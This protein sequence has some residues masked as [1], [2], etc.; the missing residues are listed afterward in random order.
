M[1]MIVVGMCFGILIWWMVMKIRWD[2]ACKDIRTDIFIIRQKLE[3]CSLSR[4]D[5]HTLEV[6]CDTLGYALGI[7]ETA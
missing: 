3:T 5:R 1:G 7:M 6:R 4:E 2:A